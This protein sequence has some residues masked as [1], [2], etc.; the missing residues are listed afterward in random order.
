MNLVLKTKVEAVINA[1]ENVHVMLF[2][3]RRHRQASLGRSQVARMRAPVLSAL[4][5]LSNFFELPHVKHVNLHLLP[6]ALPVFGNNLHNRH[7]QDVSQHS[8]RAKCQ[9]VQGRLQQVSIASLLPLML[10]L[11]L[12]KRYILTQRRTQVTI[13]K[14]EQSYE[15]STPAVLYP[16]PFRRLSVPM[17]ATRSSS[18]TCRR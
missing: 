18:T 1:K 2:G 7:A 16:R 3:A 11:P 8:Q 5:Y 10:H 12:R 9:P 15:T 4:A 13:Q 17:A 14:M 6:P